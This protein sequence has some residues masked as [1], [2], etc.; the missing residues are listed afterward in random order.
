MIEGY[1]WFNDLISA[2][3]YLQDL[4]HQYQN[5]VVLVG[6]FIV[7]RRLRQERIKLSERVDTLGQIVRATRDQSEAALAQPQAVQSRLE[8]SDANVQD[9]ASPA[10]WE[11]V[12]AI[13]RDA[14][15][16]ME[17]AIEGIGSS[18][19]RAKYS[20]LPR[21]TYRD[22]INA[23]ETDGIIGRTVS[24]KLR[25]MDTAFNTYKFRPKSVSAEEVA[26]FRQ[27]FELPKSR[28]P[29]LPDEEPPPEP[30]SPSSDGEQIRVGAQAA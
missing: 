8:P 5:L 15:D 30:S 21:Y 2:L 27:L 12:R 23:L 25:S 9:G 4:W 17:L 22:V 20:K 6:L 13:W 29:K 24:D 10:N 28:L 7:A 18:R 11:T 19:T 3:T 26:S 1:P 16:R 14:R